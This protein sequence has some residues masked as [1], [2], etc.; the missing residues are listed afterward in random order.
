MKDDKYTSTK[1]RTS[2]YRGIKTP[3]LKESHGPEQE[4]EVIGDGERLFRIRRWRG[5]ADLG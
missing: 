4:I 3:T 1:S 2:P 5:R